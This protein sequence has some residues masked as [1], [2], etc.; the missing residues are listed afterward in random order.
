MIHADA[1]AESQKHQGE[2]V[3]PWTGWLPFLMILHAITSPVTLVRASL[4]RTYQR[5][6][7]ACLET[8]T[9]CQNGTEVGEPGSCAK[10]NAFGFVRDRQR[11]ADI[12]PCY[13]QN[14]VVRATVNFGGSVARDDGRT[15]DIVE[16]QVDLSSQN[17]PQTGQRQAPCAG[18]PAVRVRRTAWSGGHPDHRQDAQRPGRREASSEIEKRSAVSEPHGSEENDAP[19]RRRTADRSALRGQGPCTEAEPRRARNP[20]R[21]GAPSRQRTGNSRE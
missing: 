6:R 16:K 7:S 19:Q 18:A 20:T 17:A 12:W 10:K 8:Q 14:A 9:G 4:Q 21:K 5:R 1:G 15:D 13:F 11:Q 2:P 3:P